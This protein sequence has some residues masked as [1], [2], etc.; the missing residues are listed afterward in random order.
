[1][2]IFGGSSGSGFGGQHCDSTS[3][4]VY[5]NDLYLLKGVKDALSYADFFKNKQSNSYLLMAGSFCL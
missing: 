2:Y 5:L 4:P 3:E 1:M